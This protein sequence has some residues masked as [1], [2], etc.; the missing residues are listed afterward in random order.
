[1][2]I[3][4]ILKAFKSGELSIEEAQKQI[5]HSQTVLAYPE[6]R[7][8]ID[9]H[10]R[11]GIPEIIYGEGKSSEQII[12]I[13]TAALEKKEKII[14]SRL[15]LDK[16]NT[17]KTHFTDKT[18]IYYEKGM[19]ASIR[20]P[21]FT[22]VIG[23]HTI[24]IFAAGTSDIPMAEECVSIAK[25]L[26]LDVLT[27]YDVG[28]AGIH[29]VFP[30]IEKCKEHNVEIVIVFAGMEGALPSVIAGM[31]NTPVIGVPTSVGY[32]AHFNGITPLL[33]MLNS[34]APGLAVVNIDNG[35]GAAVFAKKLCGRKK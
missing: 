5:S 6:A 7:F 33:S 16:Y 3:S 24:A 15:S 12:S 14:I 30:C 23:E 17:I 4:E 22:D 8:D 32:G 34:C 20:Q 25:E 2:K 21:A 27:F 13:V 10:H 9:R 11:T 18:C 19:V 29:R 31:V 28:V 35:F 26:D 1:M